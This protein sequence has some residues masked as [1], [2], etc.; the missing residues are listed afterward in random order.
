MGLLFT[1]EG[2]CIAPFA[3]ENML[4]IQERLAQP[5]D[6]LGEVRAA[7]QPATD[8]SDAKELNG[9]LVLAQQDIQQLLFTRHDGKSA[10]RWPPPYLRS[11]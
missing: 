7:Q 8:E 5:A 4:D 1:T 9:Q 10:T 3:V 2:D 11:V 6:F